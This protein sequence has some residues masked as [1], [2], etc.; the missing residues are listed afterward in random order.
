MP[1]ASA[2]GHVLNIIFGFSHLNL[3][4]W[5]KPKYL[6]DLYPQLKLGAK[7]NSQKSLRVL[8]MPLLLALNALKTDFIFWLTETLSLNK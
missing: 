2:G 1:P 7:T 6:S 3:S 5:L 8:H 4:F